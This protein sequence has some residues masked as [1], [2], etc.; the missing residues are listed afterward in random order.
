MTVIGCALRLLI[1]PFL[2]AECGLAPILPATRTSNRIDSKTTLNSL[3]RVDLYP[4][5]HWIEGI[6]EMSLLSGPARRVDTYERK[7]H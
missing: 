3:Q 1:F 6:Q 5:V 4:D 7:A 2:L